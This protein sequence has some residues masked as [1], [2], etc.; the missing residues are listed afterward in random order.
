MGSREILS[1]E[2][3]SEEEDAYLAFCVSTQICL[4]QMNTLPK[5][6]IV[7]RHICLVEGRKL[8]AQKLQRLG[9]VQQ[10]ALLKE[11]QKL[12]KAGLIYLVWR[13]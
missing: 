7:Q 1:K 10:D 2:L 13:I 4:F 11:V 5:V 8:V 9:V 12:L 3:R 6:T